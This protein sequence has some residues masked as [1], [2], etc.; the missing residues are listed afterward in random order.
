MAKVTNTAEETT[1]LDTGADYMFQIYTLGKFE[2]YSKGVKITESNKRSV[3]V[4]NLFKYILAHR[5]KMISSDELIE[6]VWGEESIEDLENPEKALQNLIYRLRISLSMNIK[7]EDLILFNQ[8]CYQWNDDF[9]VWIDAD[10][11]VKFHSKGAE[12]AK[13]SPYEAIQ[14]FEKVIG[15]Y[16]GEFLNDMYDIWAIPLKAM[17]KNAYSESV[18]SLLKILDKHANYDAVIRVCNN[19]FKYELFDEKAHFY[20]L[21]AFVYMDRKADAQRY[22]DIMSKALFREFGI[23]PSFTFDE[24]LNSSE[25]KHPVKA[26]PNIN[27]EFIR[28]ILFKDKRADGAYLCDT[29]TFVEICK[30]TTRNLARS[31]I[32]IVMILATFTETPE[33]LKLS[34]ASKIVEGDNNTVSIIEDARIKLVHTLRK[35]DVICHWNKTQTFIMMTNHV[36]DEADKA[37]KR[38]NARLQSEVLHGIYDISYEIFSLTSDFM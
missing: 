18:L 33:T 8:D 25:Q 36:A 30:I 37:M 2:I 13:T 14:S 38:I 6:A 35:G 15:L 12:L 5:K 26:T 32:S 1:K 20:F 27:S 16:N 19:Y 34:N 31:D 11:L 28:N 22:Y 7:A 23:K 17:Y 3:R 21:R 29:E 9:P 4:W 24:I 10:E